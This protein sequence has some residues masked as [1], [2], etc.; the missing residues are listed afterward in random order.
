MHRI[1]WRF[2]LTVLLVSATLTASRLSEYRQPGSL[3]RPLD[4]IGTE[5]DGWAG[6]SDPPISSE[7]LGVLKPT[8]YLSRT[9]RRG[10]DKLGLFIAFYAEQ[11]AGESMHSPKNCLPGSGWEVSES[12]RAE[13]RANGQKIEVNRYLVQNGFER[14]LVLYWYQSRNRIIASEYKGKV[15]LLRDALVDGRTAGSLVRVVLPARPGAL[16]DGLAFAST[17]IAQMQ[18]CLADATP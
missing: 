5:I 4:T 1:T 7:I 16:E 12:G 18:L 13:V 2:G 10:N 17:L 15:C 11:R 14:T 3:A 9:Y 6:S 8:S